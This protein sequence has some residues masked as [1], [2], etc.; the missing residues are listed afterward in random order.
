[1]VGHQK[2][3]EFFKKKFEQNQLSHAYLFTGQDGIGKKLFAKE[4]S[5]FIIK[6]I[7]EKT[8]EHMENMKLLK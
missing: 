4:F 7:L 8:A 6:G 1:M 3:W 2:Q 5:E